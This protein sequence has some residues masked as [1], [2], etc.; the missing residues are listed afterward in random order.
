[1]ASPDPIAAE[2]QMY[3]KLLGI[4]DDPSFSMA[5]LKERTAGALTSIPRSKGCS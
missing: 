3:L 5:Y 2:R 1:M 4:A